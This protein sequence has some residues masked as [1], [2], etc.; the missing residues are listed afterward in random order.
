[1]FF[2]KRKTVENKVAK[3][4]SCKSNGDLIMKNCYDT[5]LF[6]SN[7]QMAKESNQVTYN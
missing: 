4:Y 5:A 2:I 1:V 3:K 6:K 7:I